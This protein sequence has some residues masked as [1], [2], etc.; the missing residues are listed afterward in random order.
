[1][2]NGANDAKPKIKRHTNETYRLTINYSDAE[3]ILRADISA[4]NYFG[5]RHG[6]ETLFQLME[7]D[8]ITMNYIILNSAEIRDYPEFRHRGISL[9]TSR[10]FIEVDTIKRIIDGMGHSKLNVLHWHIVDTHSFPVE[11]KEDPINMM[12]TYGAYDPTKIYRQDTI[13]EIVR[14]ANFR[15]VRVIPE[16]DQPAHVGNGWQFP[17]AEDLTVCMNQEPWYKWCVEPPCGQLDPTK[18]KVYDLL[19]MIY[20]EFYDMFDFDSFHMGADEVHLGCW[21]SSSQI[22]EFMEN[23]LRLKDRDE[24][25]FIHL[26]SD[27]QKK[28]S[29]RLTGVYEGEDKEDDLELIVWTSHLTQE[30]YIHELPTDQYAIHIWTNGSDV[31]DSTI[32]ML[33]DKGYNMIFSNYDALYLDCGYSAWVG[34]GNNWCSP[35]KGWQK[36]YSNDP[37]EMLEMRNVVLT[38]EKKRQV[39]GGEV[40]MWTE[41]VDTYSVESKIF[42]RADALAE[43]LWSNPSEKWYKAEQRMLQQRWRLT[44]R[45][46]MADALQPEWCRINSGQCYVEADN[47][48]PDGDANK[49]TIST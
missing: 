6:I 38:E 24:Q 42:P 49:L 21:N 23:D 15:G 16:F 22:T 2:D 25:A 8:D 11:L 30:K 40:A 33:A 36:I 31:A 18:E 27:F 3:K 12:A 17:G 29:E 48:L 37:Y 45:G 41:Q 44:H 7:Y 32:K 9:D 39:L 13:R 4:A 47:P 10:N 19:E 20:R 28:S 14:H 43:R 46:I 34:E 5:A 1:L 35:Y 26:W